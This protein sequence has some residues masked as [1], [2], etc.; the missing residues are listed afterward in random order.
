[1]HENDEASKAPDTPPADE[2]EMKESDEAESEPEDLDTEM[3]E[4]ETEPEDLQ[5]RLLRL[6]AEFD[7]YRKRI[8]SRFSEAAQFAGESILLKFLQVLDNLER[9]LRADFVEDPKAAKDGL[10]AIVQQMVQ[11]LKREDVRPIESHGKTFDPYFQ[12]AVA[13][14]NDPDVPDG[15]IVEEFQRGYMIKERV[16]RPALVV[17]NRH[18]VPSVVDETGDDEIEVDVEFDDMED[19]EEEGE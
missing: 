10:A 18:V 11:I 7:N 5:E 4:E 1:M 9:A 2:A 16:L 15:T 3:P 12:H 6:Q 14:S 8:E 19:P 17:V 13:T